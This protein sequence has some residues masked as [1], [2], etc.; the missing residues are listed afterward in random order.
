MCLD[1]RLAHVNIDYRQVFVL[2]DSFGTVINKD[3]N[4][5]NGLIKV[6]VM[7]GLY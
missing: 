7:M 5:K 3:V 6:D 2:I 1:M 4:A